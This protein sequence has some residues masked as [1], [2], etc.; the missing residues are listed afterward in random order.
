MLGIAIREAFDTRDYDYDIEFRDVSFKYSGFEEYALRHV[1]IKLKISE[2]L[3][4]IR[5]NGSGKTTFIKLLRVLTVVEKLLLIDLP[6]FCW[7]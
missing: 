2:R 7:I 1:N 3:A 5:R 6:L 4:V